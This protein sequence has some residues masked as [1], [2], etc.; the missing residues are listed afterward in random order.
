MHNIYFEALMLSIIDRLI[1]N[2]Y[3]FINHKL[4]LCCRLRESL[5]AHHA[6]KVHKTK[7]DEILLYTSRTGRGFHVPIR[8]ETHMK[9]CVK[10]QSSQQM[11]LQLGVQCI[12]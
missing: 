2:V 7:A 1:C 12:R 10:S 3:C 6:I 11:G 9:I 4:Q 8:Y 5:Q